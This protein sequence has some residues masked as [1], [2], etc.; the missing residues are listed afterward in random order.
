MLVC[1]AETKMETLMDT[2]RDLGSFWMVWD[3]SL[4]YFQVSGSCIHGTLETV[5]A[6]RFAGNQTHSEGPCR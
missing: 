1:S 2:V 3:G 4:C 5:V 6:T